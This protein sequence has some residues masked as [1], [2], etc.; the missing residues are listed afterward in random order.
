MVI[1][2]ILL[3]LCLP[4]ILMFS[5]FTTTEAVSIAVAVPVN[6]I[7]VVIEELVELDLDRGESFEVDYLISPTEAANKGVSFLFSPIGTD[8]LATF[9]VVGNVITP[10]SYGSARVTVE[11]LDG[12]YRDS[13]DVV[14]YS[15][16]VESIASSLPKSTLTV[17]ETAQISTSYNP[18]AVRDTG[19]SY[20]VKS[21]EGIVSVTQSGAVRATG[22]GDAVIEVV[23]KDNPEARCDVALRV[24]SS[25]II[26]FVTDRC[27]ITALDNVARIPAVINPDITVSHYSLSFTDE[28]GV[29]VPESVA[30]AQLEL[31][32]GAVICT[33]IDE[34]FVGK[35]QLSV[36]VVTEDRESITKSCYINRISEIEIGW[37]DKVSDGRYDVLSSDTGGVAIGI[38]LRPLGADVSYTVTLKYTE[39]QGEK[40]VERSVTYELIEGEWYSGG[41]VTV[42]IESSPE[43]VSLIARGDPEREPSFDDFANDL[44]VTEIVLSVTNN[45]DGSV[46]VLDT[47]SVMVY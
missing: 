33:F 13:F 6:G 11:T 29:P 43:G 2:I 31:D 27:D 1:M 3:M 18:S 44:T 21:G 34:A 25:G 36:T 30:I 10:T 32:G 39:A 37:R 8:K 4:L 22:I 41:F 7:D 19:L 42:G 14:V 16:R 28:N 47:V 35:L 23:S 46:T 45:H 26:D 38:E 20:R 17:G 9:S 12:G 40:L 15:K 24:I 5:L